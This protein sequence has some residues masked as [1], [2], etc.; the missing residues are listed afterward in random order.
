MNREGRSPPIAGFSEDESMSRDQRRKV[1]SVVNSEIEGIRESLQDL[2]DNTRDLNST[3]EEE[4]ESPEMGE[5][6]ELRKFIAEV[7]VIKDEFEDLIAEKLEEIGPDEVEDYLDNLVKL[8]RS[9]ILNNENRRLLNP[10][11]NLDEAKEMEVKIRDRIKA[12]KAKSRNEKKES[13]SKKEKDEKDT[14]SIEE[15]IVSQRIGVI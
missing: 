13:I 4:T 9:I 12:T 8:K 10:D 5:R 15:A 7:A 2:F 11:E 6:N 1:R 14:I 3:S